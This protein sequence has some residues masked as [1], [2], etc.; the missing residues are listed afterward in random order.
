MSG[1]QCNTLDST[2]TKGH[3]FNLTSDRISPKESSVYW[4]RDGGIN[5][6]P[7]LQ[8]ESGALEQTLEEKLPQDCKKKFV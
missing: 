2:I 8:F 6:D 5:N 4:T 7:F 3:V 1:P